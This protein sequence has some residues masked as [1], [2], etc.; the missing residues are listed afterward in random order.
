[1]VS[2]RVFAGGGN[3]EECFFVLGFFF[4]AVWEKEKDLGPKQ[5]EEPELGSLHS[6]EGL[7]LQRKGRVE[8]IHL[9][10]IHLCRLGNKWKKSFSQKDTV[11]GL[12]STYLSFKCRLPASFR[13]CQAKKL[14]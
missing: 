14:K 12:T 2:L 7:Y 3:L 10:Q 1:M 6:P 4:V 11:L 13:K 5:S 8:K 9:R